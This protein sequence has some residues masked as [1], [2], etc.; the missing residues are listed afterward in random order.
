MVATAVSDTTIQSGSGPIAP[1]YDELVPVF[2]SGSDVLLG[3]HPVV[4]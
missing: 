1:G 2:R 4:V 3:T